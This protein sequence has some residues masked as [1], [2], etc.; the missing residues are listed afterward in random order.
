MCILLLQTKIVICGY[1]FLF[2]HRPPCELTCKICQYPCRDSQISLCCRN[3]FCNGHV[4]TTT[5]SDSHLHHKKCPICHGE[6]F[7]YFPDNQANEKIQS[8]LVYCPNKDTG[9]DWMGQLNQV[10]I[11]VNKCP[12]QEIQCTSNCGKILQRKLLDEHLVECPH[13]CH[14]CKA[15]ANPQE[16]DKYHKTSCQKFPVPCSNNCG[17]SI[18]LDSIK[19]HIKKCPRNKVDCAYQ[20]F[21]CEDTILLEEEEEHYKSEMKKHLDLIRMKIT[22]NS[23]KSLFTARNCCCC[24]NIVLITIILTLIA[25]PFFIRQLYCYS[26]EARCDEMELGSLN[27][28]NKDLKI[29]LSKLEKR[30]TILEN[31]VDE[32]GTSKEIQDLKHYMETFEDL[33]NHIH[34]SCVHHAENGIEEARKLRYASTSLRKEM[35]KKLEELSFSTWRLHLS[36]LN[37]I[38]LH[39]DHVTPVV[40]SMTNYSILR[41]EKKPWFSSAFYDTKNGNQLCLSVKPDDVTL[42]VSLVMLTPAQVKGLQNGLF[43][44]E[45]LNQMN[46]TDHAVD[47]INLEHV[48]VPRYSDNQFKQRNLGHLNYS[49][50]MFQDSIKYIL[51]DTVYFRVAFIGSM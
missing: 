12:F 31:I 15:S 28:A 49:I 34:D 41:K 2:V 23:Q 20:S 47:K 48:A 10:E 22:T 16:I 50:P 21:G 40:L 35:I 27:K 24:I 5:E 17:E 46:D 9:C 26:I 45:V 51:E 43:T 42:S 13:Y 33:M 4:T 18:P 11:H 32:Y 36:N 29:K 39:G 14:Y 19:E 37:L 8:L 30:I 6:K 3:N 44:I 1:N 7:D 38:T 25:G